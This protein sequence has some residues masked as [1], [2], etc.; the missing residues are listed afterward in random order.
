MLASIKPHKAKPA[1]RKRETLAKQIREAKDPADALIL[2]ATGRMF[3]D[4][5]GP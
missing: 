5:T 3:S 1:K 2:A 4:R